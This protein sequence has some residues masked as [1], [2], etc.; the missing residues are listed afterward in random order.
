MGT[1]TSGRLPRGV[2]LTAGGVVVLL[3][4][5]A[6][7]YGL[8]RDE[9]YFIVAGRNLD[10]GYVDQPPFVPLIARLIETLVGTSPFALRVLP[11]LAVAS[12]VPLAASMARRFGAGP[13]AQ[14]AVAIATGA[15]GV[16]LAFGHLLSTAA[17]D[18]FFWGVATW[19]LV[20]ILDGADPRWWLA[21]GATVGVGLQNKHLIGFYAAAILV[22]LLATRQRR[23]LA[24]PWPWAGVALAALIALPN[25]I[26]QV[27]NDFPQLEMAEALARRSDG[28]AAFVFQQIG[29]LSIALAVPAAV[30][31]WC[32]MRSRDLARWRPIAWA[33]VILF[34]TFLATG[35]KAYYM[36]PLY[37][38][39]LAAASLWFQG[40][41]GRAG[42]IMI[43]AGTVGIAIGL[44][45][46][47]PL[48][49][50]SAMSTLDAT[51][52][53]G[54]TVGWPELIDQVAA[55]YET[56]PADQRSNVAIFTASYGEAG[57][58][59]VLGPA[60]GLPAA[61]SGHN[62]YW[63]WGPPPEHGPIIGVGNVGEILRP[64]CPD[65][66]QAGTITNPYGVQNEEYGLPLW[67]CMEPIVQLADIW[68][69]VRH[70]N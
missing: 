7:R 67:L 45:I 47:L 23:V 21:L 61:S 22:G 27:A 36:A 70:Y 59:D 49:P 50:P 12:V 26:W 46:S 38:V 63:R 56:V 60:A 15:A 30:G 11:A 16:S 10:W 24:S 66:L 33:F 64:I 40:L 54:E 32:L 20:R 69:D 17:F 65:L 18:Y 52:E 28:P 6:S 13:R 68:D 14:V 51:G 31:L 57:A 42:R 9:V 62:T 3:L 58:I 29:L 43:G 55:V 48:L 19:V 1:Q 34:L 37:P 53:L 5:V 41:S 44:F 39:L 8:H 4:S 35:G 25:L 2:W